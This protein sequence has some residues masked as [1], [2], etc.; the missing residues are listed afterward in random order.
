MYAKARE[1]GEATNIVAEAKALVEGL[2]WCV[3]KQLHPLIM[4][5]DSLVMKKIIDDE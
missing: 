4:K 2:I 3:E 5:T 1:I